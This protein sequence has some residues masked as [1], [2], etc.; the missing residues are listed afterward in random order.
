MTGP[1]RYR[2]QRTPTQHHVTIG[3]LYLLGTD[4]IWEYQCFTCE[5]VIREKP[6]VPVEQW[7]I[8]RVTA[9]PAGLYRVTITYSYRFARPLPLL[10]DV[11][12]FEGVRIHPGNTQAD[13]DGCILPGLTAING[14][15]VQDSREAMHRI[16]G[17]MQDAIDQGHPVTLEILNPGQ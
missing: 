8:R 5:D 3:T 7:K 14:V 16:Q 6:G 13:T 15:G 12:G 10:L 9:I 11:P 17:R 1:A 2:L 4:R